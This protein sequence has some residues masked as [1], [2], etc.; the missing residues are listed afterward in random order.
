MNHW[1]RTSR[2]L[3]TS[4]DFFGKIFF[5]RGVLSGVFEV[6]DHEYD[7]IFSIKGKITKMY[8]ENVNFLKLIFFSKKMLEKSIKIDYK[9]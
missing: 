5:P 9:L 8:H 3:R 6:A 2:Y 1:I 7:T 4:S